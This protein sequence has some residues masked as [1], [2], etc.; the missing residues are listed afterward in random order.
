MSYQGS[1]DTQ[2]Q[3]QIPVQ[4]DSNTTFAGKGQMRV[5][6]NWTSD[7]CDYLTLLF[8]PEEQ[9]VHLSFL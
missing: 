8:L 9:F 4:E 1:L 7:T 2:M 3:I 6:T 5:V